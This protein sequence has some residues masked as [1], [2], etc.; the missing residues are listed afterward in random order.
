MEER[1]ASMGTSPRH[2]QMLMREGNKFDDSSES[3]S[4]PSLSSPMTPQPKTSDEEWEGHTAEAYQIAELMCGVN[5]T[6]KSPQTDSH[7]MQIQTNT[8]AVFGF[9]HPMKPSQMAPVVEIAR[10][11]TNRGI[12]RTQR[13]QWSRVFG[14]H[15]RTSC[16]VRR[17]GSKEGD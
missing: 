17:P 11:P 13:L 10:S 9:N 1:I 16:S 4:S 7:I 8:E 15:G 5:Q 6:T 12:I 2:I 14:R 3:S